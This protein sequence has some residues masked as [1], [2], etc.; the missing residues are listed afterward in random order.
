[1]SY[2]LDVL[3]GD[4]DR[5]EATWTPLDLD[6]ARATLAGLPGAVA[7]DDEVTWELDGAAVTFTLAVDDGGVLRAVG[8]TV[9]DGIDSSARERDVRRVLEVLLDLADRL[10]ARVHDQ[11][12]GA[13]V[14][15]ATVEESVRSFAGG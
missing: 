7:V 5:D 1:M 6:V 12:L 8:A 14:E 3:A 2:D 13:D 9:T 11:Q 15:P 4:L 10:G